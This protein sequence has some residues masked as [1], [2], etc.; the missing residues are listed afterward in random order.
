V[1]FTQKNSALD[2]HHQVIGNRGADKERCK[3]HGEDAGLHDPRKQD[4]KYNESEDRPAHHITP[5]WAAIVSA[6]QRQ[7]QIAFMIRCLT[8]LG[9]LAPNVSGRQ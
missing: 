3:D 7:G 6:V 8:Y 4:G 1:A 5:Y 9:D 2:H